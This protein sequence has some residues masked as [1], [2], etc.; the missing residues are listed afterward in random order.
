MGNALQTFLLGTDEM[1]RRRQQQLAQQQ[2]EQDRIIGDRLRADLSPLDGPGGSGTGKMPTIEQQMA[3]MDRA[4]LLSPAVADQFAPLVQQR[5]MQQLSGGLPPNEQLAIELNPERA[6]QAYASQFEDVP[7]AAGSIRT[8]GDRPIVGA[9]T[10]QRFDDR[11]GEHNPMT[12]RVTYSQPRD[13]TFAEQTDRFTATSGAALGRDRLTQDDRHFYS[14]QDLKRDELEAARL[15]GERETETGLRREFNALPEVREFN[16]VASAYGNVRTAAENPS[17]AGDL[18][19]IFAYMKMLD[20]SSVVREQE[21]ANAQNAAGVPDQVR[22]A[23]NRALRGER[24]NERQR[25]DFVSQAQNLFSTRLGRYNEIFD[26]YHGLAQTY[27]AE[28][29]RV[30]G[31]RR[32]DPATPSRAALEAEARRRGLIR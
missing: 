19:L 23:Y 2:M 17:A 7:L 32:Q 26:Q 27:G 10:V 31:D 8:R 30:T 24:L 5:R 15:T 22:N 11:F 1:E 29:E 13:P 28:P 12:G 16:N 4:R 9:P 21:F 25:T 14:S 3:A 18:S 6:G 20:P